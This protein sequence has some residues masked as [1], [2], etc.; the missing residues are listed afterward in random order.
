MLISYVT[1]D[2]LHGAIFGRLWYKSRKTPRRQHTSANINRW[3]SRNDRVIR[4]SKYV[5]A[6][7]KKKKKK[8]KKWFFSVRLSKEIWGNVNPWSPGGTYM[9]HKM[10]TVV[11]ITAYE[12]LLLILIRSIIRK[13]LKWSSW[14]YYVL[15]MRITEPLKYVMAKKGLFFVVQK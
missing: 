12:M 6:K 3:P 14:L 9:I 10:P 8:K 7:K 15:V 4:L 1:E 11:P 13:W 2:T 5:I